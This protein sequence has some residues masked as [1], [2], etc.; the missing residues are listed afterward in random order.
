MTIKEIEIIYNIFLPPLS[1]RAP[2]NNGEME[3]VAMNTDTV[4]FMVVS[5]TLNSFCSSGRAGIK[6]LPANG[7][8]KPL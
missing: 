3:N 4:A 2:Q 6:T 7:P 5:E 8:K 1:A